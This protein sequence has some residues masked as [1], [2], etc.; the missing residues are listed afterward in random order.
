MFL[1]CLILPW[2]LCILI[3]VL[4]TINAF[5]LIDWLI[6]RIVISHKRLMQQNCIVSLESNRESLKKVLSLLIVSRNWSDSVAQI[7]TIR[8][9][10]IKVRSKSNTENHSSTAKSIF[11]YSSGSKGAH[12]APPLFSE[13]KF[14][15]KYLSFAN[16]ERGPKRFKSDSCEAE[17][18]FPG[19]LIIETTANGSDLFEAIA[20]QLVAGTYNVTY[21]RRR[22]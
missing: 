19:Y 1:L 21:R 15:K 13:G 17:S 5:W 11:I 20:H 22:T 4:D 16:S 12:P 3:T 8:L 2:L 14:K 9:R 18:C 7:D 6:V 10:F